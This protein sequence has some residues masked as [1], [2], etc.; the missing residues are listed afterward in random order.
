V[1]LDWQLGV[2]IHFAAFCQVA[3]ANCVAFRPTLSLLK[4]TWALLFS[5]LHEGLQG[6][7]VWLFK[8]SAGFAL[9]LSTAEHAADLIWPA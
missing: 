3:G 4:G 8:A 9:C 6:W 7:S 2:Q 5:F 1:L